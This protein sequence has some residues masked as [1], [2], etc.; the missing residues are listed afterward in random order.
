MYGIFAPGQDYTSECVAYLLHVCYACVVHCFDAVA[1][2]AC[3]KGD[4]YGN[5]YGTAEVFVRSEYIVF[6]MF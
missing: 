6:S 1:S 3:I 2:F 4:D 5:T